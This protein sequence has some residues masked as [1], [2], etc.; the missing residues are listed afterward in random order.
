[1]N[2]PPHAG[3][4]G[5]PTA[6]AAA[7]FA[8]LVAFLAWPLVLRPGSALVDPLRIGGPE[9]VWARSD[10]DLL[11][12]IVAWTAHALVTQP[13]SI[14]QGNIFHPAPDA[15]ASSEHLLGL[16]PISGPV[17]WA[18]GNAV[19]TYNLTVLAVVWLGAFTTYLL[20]R[21]WSGRASAGFLAGALFALGGE[22]PLSFL[23]LH[24]TSLHLYPLVLLLAW[25]VAEAPRPR[26]VI[27]LALAT[28]LQ[29]LAGV[30]VAFGLAALL[31]AATPSLIAHARRH[32]RSGLAPLATLAVG[33]LPL[34][35]VAG[36]YLRVQAA[37]LLLGPAE[38]LA[39][40]TR[41]SDPAATLAMRLLDELTLPGLGLAALGL[42]LARPAIGVRTCLLSIGALG[43][44]LA[45]GTHGTL[46]GTDGPSA[47][48]ILMQ[49]VPGFAGMRAP[50]RFL[51][52]TQLALAAL[53]G[54]GAAALVDLAARRRG[55]PAPRVVT[56]AVLAFA[57]ASVPL[58][59]RHWPL[60]LLTDP[61]GGVYVGSHRWLAGHAEPG[62]VLDLP[63]STSTVDGRGIISTG[64][65]M[66]GSTL[67][68]FPMLNGYSG[69]PPPLHRLTM[70]LA[71]RLPD[72]RAL[73]D[74]CRLTGLRWIIVHHGLM[75]G[76]E[77]EWEHAESV[78]PIRRADARGRDV[79]YE[80]RCPESPRIEGWEDAAPLA[81]SA[82]RARMR[83]DLP[84]LREHRLTRI[85]IELT[86][87]G[88]QTWLGL[89]P[90]G[91]R[92]ILLRPRWLDAASGAPVSEDA[93]ALLGYDVAPGE[94][95]RVQLEELSP[96]AGEYVL[97]V[98]VHQEGGPA[99]EVVGA[100]RRRVRVEPGP[101]APAAHAVRAP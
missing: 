46:P 4:G 58:R 89:R 19:L 33:A 98:E 22:I 62:P 39:A 43:F 34:G 56:L 15:L 44:V 65:A 48:E 86:N 70:T 5:H 76:R 99:F 20:V 90:R 52:L 60:P 50:G 49:I 83:L 67:H 82:R 35:L 9:A 14:F 32:R 77:A 92:T 3:R 37:G 38:S 72:P 51:Y 100:S 69:Y 41:A 87:L 64:R 36:P 42:A 24:S 80:V 23:R 17:F 31:A 63:A 28:A 25:R 6:W 74:L 68:W 27:G 61:L 13:W 59:V 10:L 84:P 26:N 97:E 79:T 101:A 95:V 21:A 18:S 2:G 40:V 93:P 47:Y 88:D 29:V 53:A 73:R 94:R 30:Y 16:L 81:P 85:W 96:R 75:P 11:V 71:Q 45:L 57:V 12:W 78:L 55:P 7:G 54:L 91:R 8:L 1:V 66:R